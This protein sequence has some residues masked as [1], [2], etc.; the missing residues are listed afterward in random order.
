VVVAGVEAGNHHAV[1]GLELAHRL[2]DQREIAGM[3]IEH[4]QVIE[5]VVEEAAA[6]VLHQHDEGF[7]AKLDAAGKGTEIIRIAEGNHRR[8]DGIGAL[9]DHR[10]EPVGDHVVAH[11]R[12][13]PLLLLRTERHQDHG[14]F[15]Q[16]VAE[17]VPRHVLE[18]VL[19]RH[20]A[21]HPPKA[22]CAPAWRAIRDAA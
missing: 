3:A 11:R 9:G 5:A 2:V 12:M 17:F 21:V 19:A 22:A 6:N 18:Q 14:I 16:P 15:R 8:G 1:F 7:G 20:G 10:G 13:R 4:H